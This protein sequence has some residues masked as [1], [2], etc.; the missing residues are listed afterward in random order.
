MK[1]PLLMI[2]IS[3]LSWSALR[4]VAGEKL[5]TVTLAQLNLPFAAAPNPKTDLAC[6]LRGYRPDELS[7][8]EPQYYAFDELFVRYANDVEDK[9]EHHQP[10]RHMSP[11]LLKAL[12]QSESSL[13]LHGLLFSFPKAGPQEQ[14]LKAIDTLQGILMNPDTDERVQVH[15]PHGLAMLSMKDVLVHGIFSQLDALNKTD[16]AKAWTLYNVRL[17]RFM[18]GIFDAG[19]PRAEKALAKYIQNHHQLPLEFMQMWQ[20]YKFEAGKTKFYETKRQVYKVA[21]LCGDQ[22][23]GYLGEYWNDFPYNAKTH[24]FSEIKH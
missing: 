7:S 15:T 22:P 20:E 13:D 5:P 16:P 10:L 14:T 8:N 24:L 21:R 2:C 17:G 3:I 12:A 19:L 23:D 11:A 6:I 18:V 4:A 9:I 1:H